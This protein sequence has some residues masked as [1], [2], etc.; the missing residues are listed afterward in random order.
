MNEP[1]IL[2]HYTTAIGL[3][4]IVQSQTLWA[5]MRSSSTTPGSC[6]SVA[7]RFLMRR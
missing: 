3:M 2:Y 1:K 7:R 5:P 6:S 4:G